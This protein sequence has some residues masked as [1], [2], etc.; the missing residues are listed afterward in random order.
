[1]AKP[2]FTTAAGLSESEAGRRLDLHGPNELPG[3]GHRSVWRIAAEVVRE[4]MFLLLVVGG[5]LYVALGDLREALVLLA[6]VV[7]VV[8]ITI[9]QERKTERA[10]E[11]LHDLASPRALVV[12]DG[13]RRRIAARELVPGDVVVLGDGDRIPADGVLVDSNEFS[14]DESL[15]TG[16]SLPVAKRA[17]GTEPGEMD[18]PGG[19]D[20]PF[21]YSGS[22]VVRGQ[23]IERVLATGAHTEIGKIGKAL[24]GLEIESSP[25][26]RQTAKLVRVFATVGIVLCVLVAALYAMLRGG[27][28]DGLLA[29]I[30]LAMA[31]LPEEYPVVLTVFLALGAWRISKKRVLTRRVPAIETL[32]SATVLCVDKTG[33]L[34]EN[35]MAV[36]E[37]VGD[38]ASV[39]RAAA[40]ACELNPSDPMER[41]ILEEASRRDVGTARFRESAELL[42][43]YDLRAD[44]LAVTHCWQS[45]ASDSLTIASKG[46]PE[47][48]ARLCALNEQSRER[49]LAETGRLAAQGRRVLA[50]A[51][52]RF[53]GRDLPTDPTGFGFSYLGLIALA[54]PVRPAVPAA[55]AQCREAGIRV[56]MITGDYPGTASAIA[57]TIGLDSPGGILTGGQLAA[58]QPAELLAAVADV[59][60]VARVVPEQKLALVEALKANGDVVAMT[61]D[62]VNDAPAL[63]AAHIGIAMGSR[64]TDVAREA[65]SLVLLDDDFESI[66][67]TIRLGRRIF[68]NIRSAMCYLL[69]VHVPTAGLALVP[70]FTGWPLLFFPVHIVFLEFVIDPACSI[71][72]EAEPA[73][74]EAMRRPPRH[75]REPLIG[76]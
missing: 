49:I 26:Q 66:V 29:G 71:A 73:D 57:R 5:A 56:V 46:A 24:V 40:L 15:L 50:V 36:A 60:V 27:W 22:L 28:L 54:D 37:I 11:A 70:L 44:L 23:G 8:A 67:E 51:E 25:L 1:M 34:T 2:S 53:A 20:L 31:V 74:A 42:R 61:G 48:I 10:L 14:T 32:G 41:A 21:L 7:V 18:R 17:A 39:L 43:E 16:E 35:R 62:G 58:M 33:T 38:A 45:P 3:P 30:T 55:L 52:G 75:P 65:A 64:G 59:N 19:D 4:P 69:A 12:R 72:F 6:S 9:Y 68:A 63:K 13:R 76:G 47:A